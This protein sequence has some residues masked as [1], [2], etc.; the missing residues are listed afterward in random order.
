MSLLAPSGPPPTTDRP[1]SRLPKP[2]GTPLKYQPLEYWDSIRLL[3]LQP[4]SKSSSDEDI[5]CTIEYRRISDFED[6][7]ASHYVALSYVWGEWGDSRVI[8]VNGVETPVTENLFCALRDV[9][10]LDESF[11]LWVDAI[12]INQVD[13]E[14]RNE[15]VRLM[16][17]IYATA[18]KSIIYLGESDRESERAIRALR[19][20]YPQHYRAQDRLRDDIVA[21]ILQR[22]WFT[23]VWV[24]QELALSQNPIIQ[25]GSHRVKWDKLG[26][27][28][29][30]TITFERLAGLSID[31]ALS[32]FA[33]DRSQAPLGL[34][35]AEQMHM[36]R[37]L[38]QLHKINSGILQTHSVLLGI[39][40][41]RRG[42]G[43]SDSRDMLY[44]HFGM[45]GQDVWHDMLWGDE[46]WLRKSFPIHYEKSIQ[47]VYNAF[48]AAVISNS[49]RLAIM[50][51]VE[52]AYPQEHLKGLASWAP[53][54]T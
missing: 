26:N 43:A 44:A 32:I 38:V 25:C 40:A 45:K 14:E 50:H 39:V 35:L 27:V 12:C 46:L 10:H 48:A 29:G 4:R 22:P 52:A 18:T 36:A 2:E 23:R 13:L 6:D 51:H 33:D 41:S 16:G 11:Y 7:L 21:T 20:P 17:T 5:K 49:E 24:L 34:R 53:D 19:Q 9:R 42:L 1:G 30:S 37:Q 28:L 8:T 15:Q 31:E 47:Q 54:W 3:C